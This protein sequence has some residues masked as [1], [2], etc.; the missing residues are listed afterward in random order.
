MFPRG[1]VGCDINWLVPDPYALRKR[2]LAH[3]QATLA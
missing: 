2:P 1:G 3:E